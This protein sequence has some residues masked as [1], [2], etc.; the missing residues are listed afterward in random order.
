MYLTNKNKKGMNLVSFRYL[1]EK[2]TGI[3]GCEMLGQGQ[4]LDAHVSSLGIMCC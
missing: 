1:L 3:L 2:A 4:K